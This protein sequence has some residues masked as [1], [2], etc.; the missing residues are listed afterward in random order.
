MIP[1][2]NAITPLRIFKVVR[3]FLAHN[4]WYFCYFFFIISIKSSISCSTKSKPCR[5]EIHS[6]N[7]TYSKVI[8]D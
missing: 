8:V 6:D 5:L 1:D 2:T 7:E 3:L 4:G